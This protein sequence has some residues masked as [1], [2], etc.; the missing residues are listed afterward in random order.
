MTRDRNCKVK[1]DEKHSRR[2]SFIGDKNLPRPYLPVTNTKTSFVQRRVLVESGKDTP[3][4]HP[5]KVYTQFSTSSINPS[6]NS[7][8]KSTIV[9]RSPTPMEVG[10]GGTRPLKVVG[11]SHTVLGPVTVVGR[12]GTSWIRLPLVPGNIL[13]PI[14]VSLW[15]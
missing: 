8:N 10:I 5:T 13:R 11:S 2:Y 1:R 4:D 14:G 12:R 7:E 15:V 3:T 6:L 9:N